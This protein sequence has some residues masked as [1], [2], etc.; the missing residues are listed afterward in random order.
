MKASLDALKGGGKKRGGKGSTCWNCGKTGHVAR[1]CWGAK[2]GKQGPPNTKGN[3]G[4][5]GGKDPGGKPS[6]KGG[7]KK[8]WS[9]NGF[10]GEC[11]NCGEVGHSA[12]WCPKGKG[13]GPG[14]KVSWMGA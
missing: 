1:D 4:K 5:G 7:G 14:G 9:P 13:G 3:E 11:Y 2:G 12:K 6:G 8:G 10:H